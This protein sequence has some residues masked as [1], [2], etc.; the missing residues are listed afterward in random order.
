[1]LTIML[2]YLG[3]GIPVGILAGLL[4]GF[5]VAQVGIPAFVATLAGWLAF[6]GALQ[7]VLAST[8]TIIIPDETF[9]A[10]SNGFIPDIFPPVP[11]A[12]VN[13]SKRCRADY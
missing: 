6:R 13:A 4:T 5:L 1:M 11:A 12:Y 3:L 10:I 7:A 9:N 8:G 2:I